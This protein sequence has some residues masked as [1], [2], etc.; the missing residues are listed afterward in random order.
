MH[1]LLCVDK[2]AASTPAI[3]YCEFVSRIVR[4]EITVLEAQCP[5]T[6][7]LSNENRA[8]NLCARLTNEGL[9]CHLLSRDATPRLALLEQIGQDDYDI[10]IMGLLTRGRR[11]RRWLRGPST[12][13]ILQKLEI[14]MLVVP[15]ERRQIKRVL[16]C[17][18]EL[19]YP[20]ELIDLMLK[21]VVPAEAE[22]TLLYVVPDPPLN[23]PMMEKFETSWGVLMEKDAPQVEFIKESRDVIEAAGID[24]R[25][26]IRHGDVSKEIMEEILIGEYD[27]VVMGSTYSSQSLYRLFNRSITDHVVEHAQRPVLVVRHTASDRD[28]DR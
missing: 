22:V 19:W 10:V 20:T 16:L 27:L 21:I 17:S 7:Q 8:E 15:A 14:P 3:G 11:F 13:R 6:A 4:A 28:K 9:S 18:G 25:V 1:I 12:R 5:A 23:Y 2:G 26:Q 24:T